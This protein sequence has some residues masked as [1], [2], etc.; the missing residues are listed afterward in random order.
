MKG[1]S[2]LALFAVLAL[3]VVACSGG[4]DSADAGRPAGTA[5]EAV[6]RVA[7][8]LADGNPEVLWQALPASYQ[9]D[10]TE[11]IHGAAETTDAALW[12][13]TFTV[14]GKLSRVLS[15]KREFILAHPM[16]AAQLENPR[17]AHANWD[18]VVGLFDVVVQSELADLDRVRDLDVEQF[19]AT[20]GGR[21]MQRLEEASALTADD[22]WKKQM[23]NLRKTKA[24]LVTENGDT[25][26]VL[27]ET[28][29]KAPKQEEYVRVEEKWVPREMADSWDAEIAEAR[30]K[31]AGFSGEEGQNNKQVALMQL[32]MFE[33]ALD[34]VLASNSAN[35][36]NS[37][38]GSILGMALS[39]AAQAPAASQPTVAIESA[40]VAQRVDGPQ[41][42]S[43]QVNDV[44]PSA[45]VPLPSP[46]SQPSAEP[47]SSTPKVSRKSRSRSSSDSIPIAQA[48]D[49]LG[50]W[51]RV[52]GRDG[53]DFTGELV[54]VG[55]GAFLFLRRYQSGTVTVSVPIAEV[56]KLRFQR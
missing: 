20:T 41:Q 8:G 9:E 51:V 55:D 19:L 14:L 5:D 38:V 48:D 15:Q 25:A 47:P 30:E 53:L 16:V 10:V 22:G 44:V 13:Q 45:I 6:V 1:L 37:A 43:R 33:G 3:S 50:E 12:N 32:A 39:A 56:E 26:I 46:S 4:D 54:A 27:V 23:D 52:N 42:A 17:E 29:G 40:P 24:T 2:R 35:E 7:H 18:A 11:L 28:P 21:L 34:T 36:F 49:Y 31:L